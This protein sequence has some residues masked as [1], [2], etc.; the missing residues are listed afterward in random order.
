MIRVTFRGYPTNFTSNYTQTFNSLEQAVKASREKDAI[1]VRIEEPEVG[2]HKVTLN[3]DGGACMGE[4]YRT[5]TG[6]SIHESEAYKKVVE[7]LIA[8]QNKP[9]LA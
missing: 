1:T 9:K 6:G 4:D 5:P 2:F 8:E 7:K 3:K